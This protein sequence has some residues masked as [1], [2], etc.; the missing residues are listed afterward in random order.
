MKPKTENSSRLSPELNSSISSSLPTALSSSHFI[1]LI[2]AIFND[3]NTD[4]ESPPVQHIAANDSLSSQYFSNV[5]SEVSIPDIQR[6]VNPSSRQS[7]KSKPKWPDVNSASALRPLNV[8]KDSG[9][10]KSD[11]DNLL[12]TS[13][14]SKP[15]CWINGRCGIPGCTNKMCGRRPLGKG[16]TDQKNKGLAMKQMRIEMGN[17]QNKIAEMKP[18]TENSSRLSPELNSS[19]SSSLPTALSSSHFIELIEAIF[20]DSNTD[21]ESPPVQ[22]IAA[23]D[24]LSSQ[25]FSNVNSEVSIP[26][27]QRIVNPSSRQSKKSK[28]KWPD[29]NSAS[30]L[31]PLNV[32]KDSGANKSDNDNLLSTSAKS[33]P[34]CWINGRCGIPGCTN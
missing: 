5:N 10:N 11:N 19:I 16:Q 25:Y 30:A 29:V 12:S 22:H 27:I 8:K 17:L 26:D 6:I 2:E 1:E 3:S 15:E 31:R 4:I 28:P 33:K 18:K 32:K 13:A 7:K 20:N 23:N 34:E 21:I 24:S 14:K 9:A